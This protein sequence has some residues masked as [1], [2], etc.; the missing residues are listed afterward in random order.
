ML[1]K[2]WLLINH[3]VQTM[4]MFDDIH[5]EF[6]EVNFFFEYKPNAILGSSVQDTLILEYRISDIFECG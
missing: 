3:T 2:Q 6:F 5:I 4:A 1:I